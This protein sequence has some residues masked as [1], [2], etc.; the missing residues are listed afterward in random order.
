MRLGTHLLSP[1]E[2]DHQIYLQSYK[3]HF[4]MGTNPKQNTTQVLDP[5]QNCHLRSPYV[6]NVLE[7]LWK[8]GLIIPYTMEM[9]TPDHILDRDAYL[10]LL[11]HPNLQIPFI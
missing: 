5:G 7:E 11:G 9:P 1:M 10:D 3:M 6:S 8:Q 2:N 4:T